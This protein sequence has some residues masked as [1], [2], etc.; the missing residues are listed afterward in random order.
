VDDPGNDSEWPFESSDSSHPHRRGWPW[1]IGLILVVMLVCGAG[2]LALNA[3][4]G[5]RLDTAGGGPVTSGAG[6]VPP[7]G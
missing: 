3:W 1:V 4:V 7:L 2:I 6:G 5:H